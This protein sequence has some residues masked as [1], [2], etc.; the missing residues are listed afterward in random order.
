[1]DRLLVVDLAA[2]S[3]NW[4]LTADG[5]RRLLEATPKGWRVHVVHAAT[6][7]DGDGPPRPSD[8]VMDA[9]RDA[10]IYYGFGIPRLLFLEAKQLQW[11]HSAAAGVVT[12]LHPE[13]MASSVVLTN[14]AGIHAIPI[15]EYIVGGVLHFLRGLDFAAD[16]QRRAEW[17]KTPF[18]RLDSVLREM[19]TVRALIV[20]TGGLGAATAERLTAL[21]ARCT[22]VRRRVELGPPPG[23]ER[24]VA[25]DQLDAELPNHDVIILAAPLT[26]ETA[27]LLTAERLDLLPPSAIIV[28]VARGAMLDDAALVE[29]LESGRLR[30]A[31]LD[32]FKEEPLASTS[33][34]WQLRQVLLTP[35][36]SPVSPGRFWPRQLDLFLD[37]WARYLRGDSL[38]NVVDKHAG[39]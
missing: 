35:H 19:D 7:S 38:R 25:L 13:M 10:E 11:V 28:N 1:M 34:L 18:V 15:A 29:R 2:T 37:N 6:S 20:G 5:E 27:Q 24:V 22:G 23:F 17:N 14:S 31:V 3:K 36:T 30:G 33:P 16:Q 21:G 39:Y 8:E 32:V 4:A 12:S 9:V 26:P